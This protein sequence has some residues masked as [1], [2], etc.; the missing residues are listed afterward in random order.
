[1]DEK[2]YFELKDTASEIFE[3]TRKCLEEKNYHEYYYLLGIAEEYFTYLEDARMMSYCHKF[4]ERG[5]E[6]RHLNAEE[7]EERRKVG[8]DK[9]QFMIKL[10]IGGRRFI[11]GIIDGEDY[12]LH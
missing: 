5:I 4:F 1:M 7:I 6:Q 9:A 10:Q 8:R 12:S 3:G 2:K 11:D